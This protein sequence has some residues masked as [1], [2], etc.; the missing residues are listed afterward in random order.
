[1]GGRKRGSAE[2][3][4]VGESESKIRRLK[5]GCFQKAWSSEQGAGRSLPW[6]PKSKATSGVSKEGR[7]GKKK[8]HWHR[9]PGRG[10][11][12]NQIS[13][14]MGLC[15]KT[16]GPPCPPAQTLGRKAGPSRVRTSRG[17]QLSAPSASLGPFPASQGR[18]KGPGLGWASGAKMTSLASTPRPLPSVTHGRCP[19]ELGTEK[20][21]L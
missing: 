7:R 14:S 2:F 15:Q 17:A 19:A 16:P 3:S 11:L 21:T 10:G 8:R 20:S 6:R 9:P 4:P 1:M 5:P 13:R 12:S 18:P